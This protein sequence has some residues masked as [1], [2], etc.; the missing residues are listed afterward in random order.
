MILYRRDFVG[1]SVSLI[2]ALSEAYSASTV[3]GFSETLTKRLYL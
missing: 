2:K 1:I 3:I